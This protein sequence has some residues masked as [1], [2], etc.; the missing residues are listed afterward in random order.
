MDDVGRMP[1][2]DRAELFAA[3]GRRRRFSMTIIEK[4][5]WVCWMLQRLFT[6]ADPPAGLIFKGGTSLSKVFNVIE[7]F[8][9]DVD[10][11]FNREDL[12]FGGDADPAAATT[13]K[14]Q[15]TQVDNLVAACTAMIRDELVPRLTESV[16]EAL[17]AGPGELW[18]L[19]LDPDDKDLQTILFHYPASGERVAE[20]E[21]AYLRPFIRLEMGARGEHWPSL[22]AEVRSYA[23]EVFPE[24]FKSPSCAVKVV[25]AERTFW[26]KATIL[27]M[28]YHADSERH[29]RD[30]QSRH[31]YDV[32]KLY[33]SGIGSKALA[34]ME[35]L[36]DVARHKSIFFARAWARFD[37]A[38]P[39][40]LRLVPPDWRIL[41]LEKDYAR[42]R[43]EMI[44]G[45]APSLDEILAA[46][47]DIEQRVNKGS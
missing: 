6:L 31:Y 19:E 47:T 42:M 29:L 38:V 13:K 28:W 34:D 20:T 16:T 3:A 12:G 11:S 43:E 30:R 40:T 45:D 26:E 21:A 4:D 1:P 22:D 35:L 17:G 18:R 37:E 8:S 14:K 23:A 46:L 9:E 15:Q 44:F 2:K 10:L 41:E 25:T 36:K 33:Q 5:F 27:H 7:R 32:V 24:Q 39:G